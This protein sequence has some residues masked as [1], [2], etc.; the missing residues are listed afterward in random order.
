MTQPCDNKFVPQWFLYLS[1]CDAG[2]CLPSFLQVSGYSLTKYAVQPSTSNFNSKG[3]AMNM[4][5]ARP[6][7]QELH[8]GVLIF[9]QKI[10]RNVNILR[11]EALLVLQSLCLLC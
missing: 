9:R 4:G 8:C 10:L 5:V 2:A 3:W 6:A 1:V 7:G 11:N